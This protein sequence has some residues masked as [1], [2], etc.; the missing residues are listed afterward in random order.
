MNSALNIHSSPVYFGSVYGKRAEQRIA[1]NPMYYHGRNPQ[2][3]DSLFN[4][5][6]AFYTPHYDRRDIQDSESQFAK[7]D[8][9]GG[10][11]NFRGV[12][13]YYPSYSPYP[14][15]KR[16]AAEGLYD[17]FVD[18]HFESYDGYRKRD[19]AEDRYGS[20]GRGGHQKRSDANEMPSPTRKRRRSIYFKR[21]EQDTAAQSPYARY[22]GGLGGFYRYNGGIM[23][24]R[25]DFTTY[26]KRGEQNGYGYGGNFGGGFGGGRY[27]AYKSYYRRSTPWPR[28]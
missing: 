23:G 28:R 17:A 8:P 22:R 10:H 13:G 14:Y 19:V 2:I 6:R 24:A 11:E 18:G 26:Y 21:G 9:F 1:F 25:T 7:R 27:G 12:G 4:P 5:H 3:Y 20:G 16:E 15:R